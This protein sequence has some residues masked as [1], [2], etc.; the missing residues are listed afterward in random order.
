MP[1]ANSVLLGSLAAPIAFLAAGAVVS[2]NL[3]RTSGWQALSDRY[4][5]R[6]Q[7]PRPRRLGGAVFRGWLGYN[8]AIFYAADQTGLYLLPMPILLSWTHSPIFVPWAE[9]EAFEERSHWYGSDF[10]MVA[11]GASEID[12]AI[13]GRSFEALRSAVAAAGVPIRSRNS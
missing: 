10:R 11:R 13:K 1:V 6:T 9:I 4:P 2:R 7:A 12:F 5:C 3:A 8:N